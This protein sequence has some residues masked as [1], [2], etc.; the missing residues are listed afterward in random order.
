M[1][2]DP[3][4]ADQQEEQLAVLFSAFAAEPPST[5]LSPLSIKVQARSRTRRRTWAVGVAAAVLAVGAGAILIP[6]I[7]NS[8]AADQAV[9]V[10]TSVSASVRR[11]ETAETAQT[12]A[13]QT[14]AGL[15][16]AFSGTGD[17]AIT[18][19]PESASAADAAAPAAAIPGFDVAVAPGRPARS[20]A[21]STAGSIV[22]SA[23]AAADASQRCTLTPLNE[24]AVQAVRQTF[25]AAV[26]QLLTAPCNFSGTGSAVLINDS[27]LAIYWLDGLDPCDDLCVTG[28]TPGTRHRVLT[29]STAV[30]ITGDDDRVLVLN[31]LGPAA[32]DATV[33]ADLGRAVLAATGG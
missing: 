10:T 21:E 25:P 18:G 16:P 24:A 28:P 19:A 30:L 5:S 9:S 3:G 4:D 1:M 6:G 27:A 33:L 23:A 8:G 29:A 26:T 17:Q 14:A 15:S 11:T 2:V 20:A 7:S 31:S 12:A 13:A 32:F 22:A